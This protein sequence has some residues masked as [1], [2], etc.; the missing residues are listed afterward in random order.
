[1]ITDDNTMNILILSQVFPPKRGGVQTAAYNTAKFLSNYGH[2]VIVVTSKWADEKRKFHKM[3]NFLVY[4]FKSYNPPEIKGITQISSLRF[5]PIML[6]KLPKII[7]RHNI[8]LIH[9]QGRLFPISWLTTIMNKIVFKRPMFLNVQGRLEVGISGK[10]E[11][12]FDQIITKHIYQKILKKII[13]VSNSL[14]ERLIKLNIKEEKIIVIPNGVDINQFKKIPNS[15]FFNNY[16]NGKRN[17]K[18]VI[19]VGRLDAQK[20]VEY[21]IRVI[22]DVIK[23]YNN[24]HF[25]IL[26]NGNLENMLKRLT[27]ELNIGEYVTFL[28]MIPLEKMVEFYSSADIFCLPSIHEG[29]PLSIAEALSIGLTIVASSTEGIPEAIIENKN[30]FLFPP[31]NIPELKKKLIKA[32]SLNDNQIK[33]LSQNNIK[34]AKN[35]YSWEKIVKNIINVYKENLY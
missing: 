8:Q 4:R 12:V 11:N 14:K 10:I 30:G 9:A 29:F 7:K 32:L 16:L 35:D 25:F 34:L 23:E 3:D 27:K 33:E 17:Y 13:C 28:D 2:N 1:M 19:F 26:G 21:L 20:G 15:N 5:N 22:P 31:R 6:F 18:K 24:V